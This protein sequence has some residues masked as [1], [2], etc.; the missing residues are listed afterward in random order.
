MNNWTVLCRKKENRR[1]LEQY[2]Q[3]NLVSLTF[4]FAEVKAVPFVLLPKEATVV[5]D[6]S[7]LTM[8]CKH[9][10]DAVGDESPQY[11]DRYSNDDPADIDAMMYGR[12]G[13]EADIIEAHRYG[14]GDYDIGQVLA[15]PAAP[16]QAGFCSDAQFTKM[17]EGCT[18]GILEMFQFSNNKQ[19][20]NNGEPKLNAYQ[21][22]AYNYQTDNSINNS[23][24]SSQRRAVV[25][26]QG[27]FQL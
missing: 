10:K 24:A 12:N 25:V 14:G 27:S 22:P 23:Q 7:K 17:A 5:I 16:A 18:T 1:L 9:S 8:G 15:A 13:I 2:L 19:I 20:T 21:Q 11:K 4:L 26:R 6:T 3:L